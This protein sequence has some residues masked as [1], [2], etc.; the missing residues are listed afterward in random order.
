MAAYDIYGT[1]KKYTH[2]APDIFTYK[3]P[4]Y[5]AWGIEEAATGNIFL[6]QFL[7]STWRIE[8]QK[9]RVLANP[10][11]PGANELGVIPAMV[12]TL[13]TNVFE[14]YIDVMSTGTSITKITTLPTRAMTYEAVDLPTGYNRPRDICDDGSDV[15]RPSVFQKECKG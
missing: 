14:A 11:A 2:K 15:Y 4:Q 8:G 5:V 12:G 10:G 1:I 9:V 3:F 7:S 6:F 13:P